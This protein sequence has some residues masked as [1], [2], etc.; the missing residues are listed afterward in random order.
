MPVERKKAGKKSDGGCKKDL[1]V[2]T[3][4]RLPSN[5]GN[6]AGS[7]VIREM[8]HVKTRQ[9]YARGIGKRSFISTV[10]PAVHTD[11]SQ[12]RSVSK[13]LFKPEEFENA[14]F[15]FSSGQKTFLKRSFLKT[16][17]SR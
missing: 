12:K 2:L 15:S 7:S 1:I 5:D 10:R 16:M 17:T 4:Q 14:G 3:H 13:T 8:S 11:P 9:H 6:V